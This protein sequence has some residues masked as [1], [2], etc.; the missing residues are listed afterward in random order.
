MPS[1]L[2]SF[3]KLIIILLWIFL[4]AFL[5]GIYKNVY[6]YFFFFLLYTAPKISKGSWIQMI[7]SIKVLNLKCKC[8]I[9]KHNLS[10][11]IYEHECRLVLHRQTSLKNLE[12]SRVN[13]SH[14]CFIPF[15]R[16]SKALS[17]FRRAVS[18]ISLFFFFL[19]WKCLLNGK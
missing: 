9:L 12:L 17:G 8:A 1:Y 11:T 2:C 13:T 15:V 4:K 14:V 19:E 5:N 7:W 3:Q 6:M 18:A 16:L 10:H